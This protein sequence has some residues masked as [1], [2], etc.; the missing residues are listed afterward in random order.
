MGSDT[1]SVWQKDVGIKSSPNFPIVTQ[2]GDPTVFTKQV[3]SFKIA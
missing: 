1:Q 3:M 2:K